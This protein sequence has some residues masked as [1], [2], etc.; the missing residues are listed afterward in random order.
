MERK[1]LLITDLRAYV[2]ADAVSDHKYI[3]KWNAVPYSTKEFDGVMLYANRNMVVSDLTIEPKLSGYYDI[4]IGMYI[5]GQFSGHELHEAFIKLSS[6]KSFTT[7][8]PCAR[9]GNHKIDE[10]LWRTV[11]MTGESITLRHPT[12]VMGESPETALALLRLVP[13]TEDEYKARM[14]EF[15]YE[16]NKNVMSTYCTIDFMYKYNPQKKEDFLTIADEFAGT[17]VDS[18]AIEYLGMLDGELAGGSDRWAF[19]KARDKF[20]Y[21]GLRKFILTED[22]VYPMI[23]KRGQEN[24][25]KMYMSM[26][27]GAWGADFPKD[28]Y[29][30]NGF[31]PKHPELRCLDRDGTPLHKMSFAYP[32]VRKFMVDCFTKMMTYGAD[33]ISLLYTRGT[34]YVLFEEPIQKLFNEKYPNIDCRELP[35]TDEKL[36]KVRSEVMTGFMRELRSMVDSF[37]EGKKINVHVMTSVKDNLYYGLDIPTWVHEG[38]ID[39]IIVNNDYHW[40][41]LPDEVWKDESKTRIDLEKYAEWAISAPEIITCRNVYNHLIPKEAVDEYHALVKDKDIKVYCDLQ[42]DTVEDIHKEAV[43]LIN[44]GVKNILIWDTWEYKPIGRIWQIYKRLGHID[45][46]HDF[47]IRKYTKM[48]RVNVLRGMQVGRYCPWWGG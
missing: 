41:N 7:V 35:N 21:E 4:Y 32:E 38:L 46:I 19:N 48:H 12:N 28:D 3:D 39:N 13:L 6:D 26:R 2:D 45:R 5:N 34:P 31:T 44:M 23:I 1:E 33:G 22:N 9:I 17:D 11:D 42:R 18:L 10:F 27:M 47:D 25:L 14:A 40:E 37:G 24:G 8:S 29:L 36:I 15:S 30:V 16:K 43:R 20:L